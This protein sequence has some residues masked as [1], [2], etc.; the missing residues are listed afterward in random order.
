MLWGNTHA[1]GARLPK[2]YD[3][4]IE[5]G[6]GQTRTFDWAVDPRLNEPGLFLDERLTSGAYRLQF[7]L[8]DEVDEDA[9]ES[10]TRLSQLTTFAIAC[11]SSIN[12]IQ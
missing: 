1:L 12:V 3:D 7:A 2:E 8:T 10:A 4:V 9:L 11:V 5:I 6:V